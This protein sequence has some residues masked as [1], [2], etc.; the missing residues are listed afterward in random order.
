MNLKVIL[1]EKMVKRRWIELWK[2]LE[3]HIACLTGLDF[4]NDAGLVAILNIWYCRN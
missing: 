4:C 1:D 3:K 2:N